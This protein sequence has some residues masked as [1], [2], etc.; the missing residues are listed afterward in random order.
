MKNKKTAGP[1]Y[2]CWHCKRECE[3][4]SIKMTR[5]K[6]ITRF[7]QVLECWKHKDGG[8]NNHPPY[9]RMEFTFEDY[10]KDYREWKRESG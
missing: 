1:G 6:D 3:L 8:G 9:P 7:G 10:L 2:V 5:E 4:E